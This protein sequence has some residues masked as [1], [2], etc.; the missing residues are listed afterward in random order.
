MSSVISFINQKGGVGQSNLS[1][2]VA[3]C[4]GLLADT[5]V[6]LIDADKQGTASDWAS[7]RPETS[8]QV[9]KMARE[10]MAQDALRLAANFDFTVIDGP[11]QAETISRS[12]IVASDLV[13][14]PIEP[15]GASRWSSDLT[16]RQ[17]KEAREFKPTLKCGFVISRK[18]RSTVLGRDARAMAADLGIP[19]FETEIE[20]RI[21][22]AE[23]TT[24]GKT[25]FEWAGAGQAAIE[26]Q[27]L[28]HELIEVLIEQNIH[29]SAETKAAVA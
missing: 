11:P 8:F 22:Y 5:K 27:K 21:A 20:Q 4:F 17:L 19:I 18:I 12:C 15:G 23:A 10:N 1:I 6:L 26:I 3:A 14:V 9:V 16:V 24:M 7:L 25:V 29:S 13:V 28:A 2:N